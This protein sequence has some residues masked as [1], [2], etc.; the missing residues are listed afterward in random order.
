MP[1]TIWIPCMGIRICLSRQRGHRRWYFCIMDGGRCNHF[2]W[3]CL[4]TLLINWL[5][6][7]DTRLLRNKIYTALRLITPNPFYIFCVSFDGRNLHWQ[8]S[9]LCMLIVD[10]NAFRIFQLF[11]DFRFVPHCRIK[12]RAKYCHRPTIWDDP[13]PPAATW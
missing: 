13:S 8:N 11:S 9:N 6:C 1:S 3:V 12:S 10:S 5:L 4:I 2:L 7:I